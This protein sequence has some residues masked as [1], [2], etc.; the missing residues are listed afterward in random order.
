MKNNI[1]FKISMLI[2]IVILN[3]YGCNEGYK[4]TTKINSDGS[5][6]RTIIVKADSSYIRNG[7]FP[8]PIDKSWDPKWERVEKDSQKAFI[9][10]KKF[11]DV[12]DINNEFKNKDKVPANIR[13]EKK[14][15]WFFTYYDYTEIY[16]EYNLFNKK[17]LS[18]FLTGDEY[19][20]YLEGDTTKILNDRIERYLTENI[21]NYFLDEMIT[22]V[23]KLKDPALQSKLLEENRETLINLGF[24]DKYKDLDDAENILA[25]INEVLKS[26][27]IYK[28]K[29]DVKRISDDILQKITTSEIRYKFTNEVIMPGI[30]LNTNAVILEG[31]KV[32]WNFSS[33][34]FHYADF[35]M[36]VESRT[37]NVW[38]II[39]SA[40]LSIAIVVLLVLPKFK[41]TSL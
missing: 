9:I 31:N 12:N 10:H 21:F 14:F 16:K 2:Y 36:T 26:K 20:K 19:K 1:V 8:V 39:L 34:R 15:R 5:C 32:A 18:A 29:D 17:P 30:I 24:S 22:A 4:S 37:T 40:I 33:E 3:F 7:Y 38:T 23:E 35:I 28:L 27:N 6:E 13:F 11:T 41:K 25:L